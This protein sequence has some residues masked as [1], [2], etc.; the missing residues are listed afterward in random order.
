MVTDGSSVPGEKFHS[1]DGDAKRPKGHHKLKPIYEDDVVVFAA[2][3][4][5][6]K[7]LN[8]IGAVHVKQIH[9]ETKEW[10]YCGKVGSGFTDETLEEMEQLFKEHDMTIFDKD[11]DAEKVDIQNT[12]GVVVMIEYSDR[13]P[14]T[15]KFKLPVFV[16]V[17]D[18]KAAKE[19]VAQRLAPDSE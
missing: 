16:R 7:R 11:K 17:R 14:G 12:S 8:G 19:C 13:Q 4:G 10:F 9:P 1:F 15:Q 18:D 2:S 6:G 3:S 5:G